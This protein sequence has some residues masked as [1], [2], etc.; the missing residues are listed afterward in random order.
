M[1]SIAGDTQA[2]FMAASEGAFY[3]EMSVRKGASRTVA[4]HQ[5]AHLLPCRA[6]GLE[7]NL[8]TLDAAVELIAQQYRKGQ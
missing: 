1:K 4:V 3:S 2:A 7:T 5:D 6:L 8:T